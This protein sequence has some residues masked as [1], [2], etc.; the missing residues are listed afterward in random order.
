MDF[1]FQPDTHLWPLALYFAFV[2]GL[3]LVMVGLS[4]VLGERHKERQTGETYE[5]GILATG[6]GRSRFN[7]RFYLVAMFF[8]IFDLESVFIFSWALVLR[9]A[10]WPAYIEMVVFIAILLIPLAYL[11][12]QGALDWWSGL[13][14]NRARKEIPPK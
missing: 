11:W 14:Q 2:L 13:P 3:A 4:W 10:G 8:V 1:P 7:S 9:R 5:G 6:K 12:R